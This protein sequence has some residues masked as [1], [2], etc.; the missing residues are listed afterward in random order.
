[1]KTIP[2]WALCALL[3][4]GG[5]CRPGP[6]GKRQEA[7]ADFYAR[8]L[9]QQVQKALGYLP[10]VPL[11]SMA[12]PRA[13]RRDGTLD[14][15]PS[16]SWT[17]GFYPGTLWLLYAHSGKPALRAAAQQWTRFVEKEQYDTRTHDLGFKL[18]CSAGQ[19]YAHTG[20]A[21]Y[22]EVILT[23]SNTLIRRF[24]PRVGCIR[25]WDFNQD[26]WQFPV[27]IDNL[28]NLEMLFEATRLS[29]DST[30]YR[31]AYQ[32]ALTT[33]AHHIRPDHS[34]F[35]VID[36]DT[37]TGEVRLRD[38]HQ[39]F[40]PAS[41]WSRGQA[42]NLYGFAMAYRETGDPRFLAQAHGIAAYIYTHPRLP[43]HGV[44]YW[45][46][47]APQIPNEPLDASAAAIIASGLLLLCEVDTAACARVLPWVDR[48]LRTLCQPAFAADTPPFLLDHSVGSIP[49]DFEVD[50]PIIY[51]DYYY[52]EA[53]MR[54]TRLKKADTATL[55][56]GMK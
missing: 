30:Y 54:R 6:A 11:D 18:F 39:G 37:L 27:I 16:R 47:D 49:G 22:R 56:A 29:G 41:A 42:W 50:V 45:D 32:H 4:L 35:H 1:M 19:G 48:T 40:S 55:T 13:L 24:H 10:Q 15:T 28:M 38:T 14:G 36:Y 51:A 25:S 31:V 2:F 53:L 52:V 7:A 23:A 9:D 12:I 20:D 17:S 33:L 46:F 26:T 21:H 3:C 44:P 43:A 34:S 8:Q 5:A